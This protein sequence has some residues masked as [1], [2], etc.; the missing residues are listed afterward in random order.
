VYAEDHPSA[1]TVAT[2]LQ[3]TAQ[4][5]LANDEQHQPKPHRLKSKPEKIRA[6]LVAFGAVTFLLLSCFAVFNGLTPLLDFRTAFNSARCLIHGQNP[7]SPPNLLRIDHQE[8]GERLTD[9]ENDRFVMSHNVYYPTEFIV[10]LP[11]AILP[12]PIAQALWIFSTAGTFILACF[13]MWRVASRFAAELAGW[14]LCLLLAT[15]EQIVLYG[16]PVGLALSLCVIAAWC[17][18][19]SRFSKVGVLCLAASLALKP[20]DAGLVWL[21]FLLAG[22][23]Y[24]RRAL[25]TLAVLAALSLP[26][27]LWLSSVSRG[28]IQ[29]MHSNWAVFAAHGQAADPGPAAFMYHGTA[30][31]TN[32]QALLSVFRDNPH[33]YNL[34]SYLIC[35]PILLIWAAVTLRAPRTPT[36][37]LYA[38]AAI[39]PASMLPVYHRIYD[40]KLI[41]LAVP[42][43][44][45]LWAEGR[46]AGRIAVAITSAGILLSADL[47]WSTILGALI[48]LHLLTTA[49]PTRLIAAVVAFPLP[50]ALLAMAT[51]YLCIYAKH[52][53][54]NP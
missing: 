53:E 16:N 23:S 24:R 1:V 41:M 5:L 29:D 52:A 7:Y 9:S 31:I 8:G 39:A 10:T 51:F 54:T 47:T 43:C 17:F 34:A 18:L 3:R 45:L 4:S 26:I 21:Y 11:F 37:A 13:L 22:G 40:A 44:A 12:F 36:A 14:L 2:Q 38:L 19:H 50:L 27:L 48:Q 46:R 49:E 15:S 20:H 25:Q 35:A 42:A 30:L 32:L 28:W 6:A 33:F